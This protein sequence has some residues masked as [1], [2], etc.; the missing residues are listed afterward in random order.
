MPISQNRPP[1]WCYEFMARR[2]G[3]T[4]LEIPEGRHRCRTRARQRLEVACP[5]GPPLHTSDKPPGRAHY[6]DHRHCPRDDHAE[7]SAA[8]HVW[9]EDSFGANVAPRN[10]RFSRRN[11][12]NPVLARREPIAVT[13]SGESGDSRGFNR[14]SGTD[15]RRKEVLVGMGLRQ[16]RPS[17]HRCHAVRWRRRQAPGR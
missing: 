5:G 2:A 15:R 7:R 1:P 12:A 16:A 3:W 11:C 13:T 14:H 6:Y 17:T 8:H 10:T 4:P 9:V